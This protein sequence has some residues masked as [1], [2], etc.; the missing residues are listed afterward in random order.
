MTL[1]RIVVTRNTPFQPSSRRPL[2]N[3]Y[4]TTSPVKIPIRLN[5]TCTSVNV[6]TDMPR[7]IAHLSRALK[8]AHRLSEQYCRCS[9]ALPMMFDS[10]LPGVVQ[11]GRCPRR[12]CRALDALHSCLHPSGDQGAA[13]D[14]KRTYYALPPASCSW[15]VRPGRKRMRRRAPRSRAASGRSSRTPMPVSMPGRSAAISVSARSICT[16]TATRS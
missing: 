7:I 12:T 14:E 5:N 9:R 2:R 11:G 6:E 15:R 3:P 13:P 1:V 10:R 8:G 4:T 16:G